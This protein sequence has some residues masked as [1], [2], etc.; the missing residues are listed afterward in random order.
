VG[1]RE[2]RRNLIRADLEMRETPQ[3]GGGGKGLGTTSFGSN[4]GERVG[5][6]ALSRL[7]K[8]GKNRCDG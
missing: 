3:V 5:E 1:K 6:R 2:K 4:E 8:R 7:K